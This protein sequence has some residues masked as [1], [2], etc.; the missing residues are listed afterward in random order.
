M[1]I[2]AVNGSPRGRDGN[3]EQLLQPFLNGARSA[4]AEVEV[5][6]LKDKRIG[7]CLGCSAC[8]MKTPGVCVQQDDM[9]ELLEKLRQADT[10]V[11]ATPLYFYTVSGLMKNFLDRHLPL[12]LPYTVK[13][14]DRYGHPKRD[15]EKTQKMV[16]ISNCGFPERLHFAGLMETFRLCCTTNPGYE[17]AGMILCP[18][19]NILSRPTLMGQFRWYLEACEAAGRE[20]AT[21]SAISSETQATLDRLITDPEIYVNGTNAF[22]KT[23]L[24]SNPDNQ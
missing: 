18:A 10:I 2:L 3:T 21:G 15:N 12:I 4:G 7:H 13:Y 1:K 23:F 16:L 22:L 8:L 14:G 20:V 24:P 11:Y 6:Y 17:L 19:G 9:T 5:I